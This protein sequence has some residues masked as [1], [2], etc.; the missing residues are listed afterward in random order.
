[1]SLECQVTTAGTAIYIA[2]EVLRQQ[3]GLASD[4]WSA[5]VIAYQL[6]TSRLPFAGEA[7]LEV[8]EAY[9][10]KQVVDHKVCHTQV[11][12]G[13]MSAPAW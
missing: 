2:P 5:G 9:M 8:S 10:R 1:M 13:C 11:W 3:Y 4:V 12:D 6:L 7:G